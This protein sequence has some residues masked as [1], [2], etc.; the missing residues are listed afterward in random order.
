M[1]TTRF[2]VLLIEDNPADARLIEHFLRGN[3][4]TNFEVKH[5]E[6]AKEAEEKIASSGASTGDAEP[7][8][9]IILLDMG[10]PDMDPN[11]IVAW[12]L[13]KAPTIP[14]V[15]LSGQSDGEV[16]VQAVREGAQDYLVKG[17][18][19]T[20]VLS[21]SI[22][23]AVERKRVDVAL[24]QSEERFSGFMRHSPAIAFIKDRDGRY[25]F[26]NRLFE[27]S[28]GLQ[29]GQWKGKKDQEI[30]PEEVAAHLRNHDEDVTK[31]GNNFE[32]TQTIST[33]DGPRE[34]LSLK[35]PLRD[36][37]EG[38]AQIAGVAIDV[39]QRVRAEEALREAEAAR[40]QAVQLQSDTLNALPA[41]VSLVD[42]KSRILIVNQAW[43]RFAGSL[44]PSGGRKGQNGGSTG[45]NGGH[46]AA[47]RNG[48]MLGEHY[49]TFLDLAC[50]REED[51][52]AVSAGLEDV[53]SGRELQ[54]ETPRQFVRENIELRLGRNGN[55]KPGQGAHES[56]ES[57]QTRWFTVIIN[58]LTLPRG[59]AQ[60]NDPSGSASGGGGAG[61][62]NGGGGG[63][64]EAQPL[65][66]VV[67]HIDVTERRRAE[68]ELTRSEERYKRVV[69][70]SLEGV[71][72]TDAKQRS[73]LVNQRMASMLEY[74]VSELLGRSLFEFAHGPNSQSPGS[75]KNSG[76]PG[77]VSGVDFKPRR[78]DLRLR[79]RTGNEVWAEV[80]SSTIVSNDGNSIEGMLYMISDISQRKKAELALKETDEQLRQAQKM[81]A[82]GQLASGVAHDFNNL[83][84]AIRGFASLARST[85]A[86]SHP[87]REALDQVEEASRQATGVAGALL[88]FARK[89]RSEM[90]PVRITTVV[91][92]AVRLFRR[93]LGPRVKFNVDLSGGLDIF[94][95]GDETQLHQVVTNLAINARD[96][97][98]NEGSIS[99][100]L[101]A[102][103]LTCL[104]EKVSGTETMAGHKVIGTVQITVTD[105]GSGMTPDVQA[106][107]FEPF[108]TTK[109]RG[110]G[111]GL[112]L[113]VIHGIILEHG[114]KV[115]VKSQ[116]GAGSTFVVTLP[117]IAPPLGVTE[118]KPHAQSQQ[119]IRG[120][121][122]VVQNSS[123][124][125]GV[126]ASMLSSLGCEAIHASS[127]ADA[128]SVVGG[129]PRGPGFIIADLNLADG[130]ALDLFH[131]LK[132]SKA[133]LGCIV[134]AELPAD[135]EAPLPG[136]VWLRKPFR[137]MDL[138]YAL[139][140]LHS[141]MGE[142]ENASATA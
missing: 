130:S 87:A 36:T 116:E 119:A 92:T 14:V 49:A 89:K 78:V 81:E 51:A 106:R 48:L 104:Y 107:I 127:C 93:T 19:D 24:R 39:T 44:D 94:V 47:I 67:M 96:S 18:I 109:P 62:G 56:V 63:S 135:D 69:E 70:T 8:W 138:Q 102:K 101:A 57:E 118:T 20:E 120:P 91:E 105:S 71:W 52:K 17:R 28:L 64:G 114:G 136:V 32:I 100:T 3:A 140:R 97:I 99:I 72:L 23:Y 137:L 9:D 45:T 33:P 80:S 53:L 90:L 95:N 34:W 142:H 117:T 115:A 139:N 134:V 12:I 13:A 74:P 43:R 61:G 35:F 31:Y 124:V 112:G 68:E 82:I 38:Y 85:L 16:A 73:T 30:F 103:D 75:S 122:L 37:D 121:A 25:T 133:D 111:T 66:A 58:G 5:V 110:R 4:D 126:V 125:R 41:L 129:M 50:V 29:D 55:G 79:S 60:V 46:R 21:R 7:G 132:Q 10:L 1:T 83:L 76:T 88:T 26:A 54:G 59:V 86:E 65:G 27:T 15:V 108:F 40:V 141:S 6:T 77:G 128:I 123:L 42:S 22:R 2:R 98:E 84:T 131:T 113:S 11:L